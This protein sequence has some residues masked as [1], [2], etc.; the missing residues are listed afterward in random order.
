MV[1][2]YAA[3]LASGETS[4]ARPCSNF[5]WL[6]LNFSIVG[7][8]VVIDPKPNYIKISLI[9]NQILLF[10]VNDLDA[11]IFLSLLYVTIT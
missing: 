9:I 2:A 6:L 11:S 7:V 3:K 10:L 5:W 1:T 4:P 8:G